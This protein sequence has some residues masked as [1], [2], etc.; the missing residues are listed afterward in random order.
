MS[1]HQF[2]LD[3][4]STLMN[5]VSSLMIMGVICSYS[6]HELKQRGVVHRCTRIKIAE[7]CVMQDLK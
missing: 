4:F 7:V 3:I 6:A 2:L 5:F 1:G